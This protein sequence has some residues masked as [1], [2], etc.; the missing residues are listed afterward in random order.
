MKK[1]K[2]LE[3]CEPPVQTPASKIVYVTNPRWE[4]KKTDA[5]NSDANDNNEGEKS[6]GLASI[7]DTVLLMADIKN[8]P[9]G[10]EVIFDIYDMSVK[11]PKKIDSAKGK[12]NS[13]LGKGEWIV[14]A[15]SETGEVPQLAFEAT[16]RSRTSSRANIPL[17]QMHQCDF[18]EMPDVLFN[19]ASAVPCLDSEGV[20]IGAV[21]A[22]FIYTKNNT[23]REAV[24]FGHSD[25]SGD[26]AY[27][28]DLSGW[29]AEGI[30]AIIDNDSETFLDIVDLASKIEDYQTILKS[31]SVAHGYTCDPGEVDN[32]SGEKTV[33]ALKAFQA[34]YNEL[35]KADLAVDGAIGSKTWTAMFK[36]IRSLVEVTVKSECGEM[37]AIEYGFSGKGI[38]SC[39]ESF[40][41]EQ[42]EKDNY[43]CMENR[44]VEIVFFD[45]GKYPE[46]L[47]PPQKAEPV[48][49]KECPVYDKKRVAKKRIEIVTS[50]A[51]D[52]YVIFEE[53]ADTIDSQFPYEMSGR[54]AA[55]NRWIYV[56]GSE[57][58]ASFTRVWEI[59]TNADG[60]KFATREVTE[61]N[62][63][64]MPPDPGFEDV[65]FLPGKNSTGTAM[66]YLACLSEFWIPKNR[67]FDPKTGILAAPQKRGSNIDDTSEV[68]RMVDGKGEEHVVLVNWLRVIEKQRKHFNKVYT[69]WEQC[70]SASWLETVEDKKH[71]KLVYEFG[72]LIV[73]IIEA[74]PQYRR[75]L[76]TGQYPELYEK[77]KAYDEHKISL[78]NDITSRVD[79]L[80]RSLLCEKF[81]ETCRD[82]NGL[83]R[84]D[85]EQPK[86]LYAFE[87]RLG[88][89]VE[90]ISRFPRGADTIKKLFPQ[91]RSQNEHTW[92]QDLLLLKNDLWSATS[93][94]AVTDSKLGLSGGQN[95]QN[96]R[97]LGDGA[98][99]LLVEG[100][101]S[102]VGVYKPKELAGI[103]QKVFATTKES[104]EAEFVLVRMESLAARPFRQVLGSFDKNSFW[105][106]G[107]PDQKPYENMFA[108]GLKSKALKNLLIGL[109]GV[110]LIYSVK[111][112]FDKMDKGKT[113]TLDNINI[114]LKLSTY[115]V[116]NGMVKVSYK[117]ELVKFGGGPVAV[118]NF[119]T[120][121]FDFV[122]SIGAGI[123]ESD[124][125]DNDAAVFNYIAAA[126]NLIVA[127][128]YGAMAATFFAGAAAASSTGIG[129]APGLL[130]A[131]TGSVIAIGGKIMAAE[132]DNTPLENM[133]L[134]TP[135]GTNSEARWP[136]ISAAELQKQYIK[137]MRIVNVFRVSIDSDAITATITLNRLEPSTIVLLHEVTFGI[138]TSADG[139]T[140]STQIV[141]NNIQLNDQNC[142]FVKNSSNGTVSLQIDLLKVC[143]GAFLFLQQW[144]SYYARL[145]KKPRPDYIKLSATVDLDGDGVLVLP[146]DKKLAVSEKYYGRPVVLKIE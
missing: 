87:D 140:S 86:E 39:G 35:F 61:A 111:E 85:A 40:P 105:R 133:L 90:N 44:R 12:H 16:A 118:A 134:K 20:L 6:E 125:Y 37:P 121:A 100:A 32:I 5:N 98:V 89:L 110:A 88:E 97:K 146:D 22:A 55:K 52:R 103:I 51:D 119:F 108:E 11:P 132:A 129:V 83:I 143:P 81:S 49:K 62:Y 71:E 46:L 77:V 115:F 65:A 112:H 56:F 123:K 139:S 79:T 33:A 9:E 45:K 57:D 1:E 94:Q 145:G 122:I 8:C 82:Y 2:P 95:F 130:L 50:V 26:P 72:A 113:G 42:A 29:R 3:E 78:T 54:E 14:A 13:G 120:S 75:H 68:A 30:K 18:V 131:F 73:R 106:F 10:A 84:P 144:E 24:L 102:G 69:Q 70:R 19:E 27:N 66:K 36:V 93:G 47:E 96:W 23:G 92:L 43:R 126:G 135:W 15:K 138:S 41:I 21:A 74:Y 124:Q 128:G 101:K 91:V 28:Y 109:E 142:R 58:G 63:V 114:L 141:G 104:V 31:L 137:A 136:S 67:L 116:K 53:T 107:F 80:C 7:G 38:Y 34:Q 60:K 76:G 64:P 25:T 59:R 99:K 17:L 4:H 127:T 48:T 117:G